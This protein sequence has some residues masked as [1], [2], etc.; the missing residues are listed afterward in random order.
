MRTTNTLNTTRARIVLATS[1]LLV[2]S[3]LIFA[4][5]PIPSVAAARQ[6]L[7]ARLTASPEVVKALS[8]MPDFLL[9]AF[10]A[11]PSAFTSSVTMIASPPDGTPVGGSQVITYTVTV[12]NDDTDDV[13]PPGG[14]LRVSFNTPANTTFLNSF[15]LQQPQTTPAFT[16]TTPPPG[17]TG[18]V[19]CSPPPDGGG[20]REFA[21]FETFKIEISVTVDSGVSVGNTISA[22]A[23]YEYTNAI[24]NSQSNTVNHPVIN[25]SGP[26]ADLRIAKVAYTNGNSGAV[27]AGASD[28]SGEIRYELLWFNNGPNP[29]NGVL[30]T[31]IIPANTIPVGTV[32]AP[33]WTC[34]GDIPTP[35]SQ[36]QCRP[37]YTD[38]GLFQLPIGDNY[39]NTG[40]RIEYVVR[41][42][43]SVPEGTFYANSANITSTPQSGG[44]P[45]NAD[46]NG[47]NNTSL[48]TS[49]VVATKADLVVTKSDSP[50]PVIAG[51]EITYPI[52]ITN[53][54]PSDA[55]NVVLND[56]ISSPLTFVSMN[57]SGA[58]GFTCSTP[59]V[60]GTGTVSCSAAV[61]LAGATANF[62][63]RVRVSPDF[64]GASVSNSA[65]AYASTSDTNLANNCD[66]ESTDVN[67]SADV[68]VVSKL[69]SPD[70]VVAGENLTYSIT[71]RNNGPSTAE[72]VAVT[73]PIPAGTSFVSASATG[74]F[75]GG[76]SLSGG[77]VV[78]TPVG[79]SL[80]PGAV[81]VI[82]LVVKVNPGASGTISNTATI[83]TTTTES[84]TGNN[85]ASSTTTVLVRTDMSIKK[86]GPV[87]VIAGN[88][89]TY[90]IVVRNNGPSD[91][92]SGSVTVNDDLDSR[93]THISNTVTGPVGFTCSAGGVDPVSC[94]SNTVFTAG[95]VATITITF[96]VNNDVPANSVIFNTATVSTTPSSQDPVP[97]NNSSTTSTAG[98]TSADLQLTK[99]ST[100]GSVIAGS[101]AAG[102]EI[103]YTINVL[104]SGPSVANGVVVSD[105]VP[106]NTT[107][108]AQ[109]SFTNTGS[110]SIAMTCSA[111]SAGAQFTCTITGGGAMPVGAAGTIT[112]RVRV[113]ANALNGTIVTN[114]ATIASTGGSATPDPNPANN[115]QDP[116]STL[117]NT[118]AD[119]SVVKDDTGGGLGP[120]PVIAGT[121]VTYRIRVNNA[122]P[123]DAQNV[124][125]TDQLDADTTFVSINTSGAPGFTCVTPAVGS[126]GTV[127]CTRGVVPPGA[128]DYDI[129]LTV[130][131]R[132]GATG[133]VTNLSTVSSS[134]S[135]PSTGNNT[136]GE[137]TTV[138]T[139]AD[140][141]IVSKTDAPDPVS[142]GNELRYIITF[143][144]NGP[145]DA[146]GVSI[147]DTVPTN[148]TFVSV[149]PPL[150]WSCSAP[151]TGGTGTVSCT[152]PGG[153]LPAGAAGEILMVVRVN[154]TV[155][156]TTLSNTAT[157]LTSTSQG[158]ATA[159]DS[160]TQTTTVNINPDLS[161]VKTG[162]ATVTAGNTFTYTLVV[163]NNGPSDAPAN[164]V[165]VADTLSSNLTFSATNVQPGSVG[166]FT[167]SNVG[168]AVTCSNGSVFQ[169]GG[170]ATITITF[171]VNTGVP[172]NTIIFNTATVASVDVNVVDPNTSNNSSTT[173]TAGQTSADLQ[174]T[175]TASPGAVTA[176]SLLAGDEIAYTIN[177]L[178]SGPSVANGVVLSDVV[179]AN[180]I[181][182]SQP[183]FTSTGSPA[184]TMS[185][186]AAAPGAQFTCAV[187]GTSPAGSMPVG[188]A[189]N[190]T[191]RVRVPANVA[192]NTIITNQAE[193]ASTGGSAT[194]DPNPSN[195]KQ[196]PTSTLVNTN[197]NLSISKTDAP[198][199]V[200]AG[201]NVTYT[202]SV[203]N[204]GPSDAQNVVVTDTLPAQVSFLTAT[205]DDPGFVCN[206]SGNVVTCAKA[207]LAAG[208][209]A[210]ITIVA[211]VNPDAAAGSMTNNATIS[212]TTSDPASGNNSTSASTTINTVA[213]VEIVSK[214]DT[215]DPVS[216]GSDLLYTITFRNNG[217][218]DAAGVNITDAVPANTTF[219]SV[220]PPL[221]WSCTAPATGG[222]GT[223]TCSPPNGI[224]PVGASG[225]ILMAVRVNA[226]VSSTTLT[227]TATIATSTSQGGATANDS[228]TQT[229]TVN[230]NPDLSIVKT[231]PATVTAGNVYTYTLV[232]RNNGPSDAPAS[233]VQVADTLD[234]NLTFN[235]T[236][237]QP[238]SVGGFTCSNVGNAV[239]CSNGSVFQA[240][241]VA[242]ITITFTVNNNVPQNTVILNTATVSSVS[243]GVVDPNTS[244]NSSTTSTAGQTS[245]DLQL[246]KTASPASV[247]AGS[248]SSEI[249][250]AINILNSGP[251]VANNVVVSDVVPSNTIVTSQ[252]AFAS[253]GTPAIGLSCTPASAGAQFT[254]VVTGTSPAGSMPVGAAGTITYRVRVPANVAINTI[255]TNQAEI[256][257]TGGS[258]TPDPNPSNNRQAPT[259]TLVNTSADLSITKTDSPDP[260]FA[261]NNVTYTLTVTNS[262]PSDAQN[263]VVT[264]SLP[265]QLS[266]VSATSSD[267][268]FVC[269]NV[270]NTVTCSKAI[271]AASASTTITIIARVN[272]GTADGTVLTNNATVSST[273]SD[274]SSANNSASTTTTVTTDADLTIVKSDSPDPVV[275]GNNLTYTI[276][277]TNNGPSDAR[278]VVLTDPLPAGTQ[279]LSLAGTGVFSAAGACT[280]NG[281]TPG[282]ITCNAT[283]GGILPAGATANV[284]VLVKVLSSV[285]A[286][287]T[288]TNTATV[289]WT[290]A[291]PD[292]D[293][294]SSTA[295][296]LV[297]HESDMTIKK[298]APD[299]VTAG[300]RM[301]YKITVRNTGPSDVDGD[302]TT[303]SI[304]VTDVLPSGTMPATPALAPGNTLLISGPGGFAC[305][306]DMPSNTV[307][308]VNAAGDPGDFPVGSVLT[309][310]IKV[311]VKSSVPAGSNLF[312]CVS[313]ALRGAPDPTPELD[314]APGNNEACD[315]TV[316]SEVL[317]SADLG[318]S[319]T[320]TAV[321]SVPG[322][323]DL[324]VVALP[325]P[326]PNVP[327]GAVKAGGYIQ[328]DVPFG[329]AGPSDAVNVRLTDVVPGN[330]ALVFPNTSP[331]T[332]VTNSTPPSTPVNLECTVTGA[333]GSQQIACSPKGNGP[334]YADGVLP[335]GYTGTLT[336]WVQVNESVSG[337]TIVSNPANITS[338]PNGSQPGTPDA[339]P[340]NNTSLP[341][342]TVVIAASQLS[343]TKIV[344]SGVTAA[345][346]PNQTGPIGPA[347][348]SGGSG[349]TGTAVLPGTH[350]TYRITIT[351]NGPSDV[352]NL[353]VTDTLPAGL[354][355]PPGRVLGVKY[356]SVAQTSGFGTTFTCA[357]PT[358]INPSNNPQGNGGLLQCTAPL[359]SANAPNNTATID[360][361]VFI[362]PATRANLV[363]N[364]RVDATINNFNQ[365]TAATTT[366]TTPVAPTSDLALTKTHAPDPVIAG[367]E[368]EY[369]VTLTNNGPSAAQTVSLVDTF[370]AFQKVLSVQVMQTPDGNGAPNFTCTASPSIG[371]P[372]NTT[373]L[374]CTAAE[375]PPNRR[376]DNTVNPSGTVTFKIRVLQDPLT[377][378]PAPTA[379]QNCVSATSGSTD[380]VSG[381]STSV[382]DTVNILFRSDLSITKSDSPDPVIAGNNLTYT[383]NATNNGPSAAL[384]M[385]IT[386]PLPTGTVF[387]SASAPGSSSLLTPAVGANGTVTATW[388][389][390]TAPGV[391][392]TLT[393]VVRVCP[394]FQQI[395]NL[396][397]AQMCVPNLTD[398]ATVSSDTP[399]LNSA[400]NS[401]TAETTVQAQSDLSI[402]KTGPAQ[403]AHSTSNNA[404]IVTYTIT[405]SNAGPSNA[406]GVAIVD[407]L[408]KGFTVAETAST[409]PGT[410]FSTT[411]TNGVATVTATIGVLGAANQCG[412]TP[413]PTS[414]T[415][416]IRAQVPIKHPTIT[417]TNTATISTTNCLADPNLANNTATF[418]TFITPPA[419]DPGNAFPALAEVGD[420]K[421]G[422]ILFYPIYT[423]DA[424]N[425][426]TQ[427]A[428]INIT[429]TSP[430]ERICVHL[431]AVDGASC[432]VL[433]AFICLTPNQTA[434][435]LASD[436]D[437]GNTGYL[438]ALSVDCD[439]GLPKA[440]NYLIGDQY[441]KFTSGHQANLAAIAVAAVT[442]F[443]GGTNPNATTTTL[444]FDGLN[445]N[446]LA[447]VVAA[448][449]IQST[450][451]NNSTMLV[452]NRV[453]GN[454]TLGGAL[455]GG[456]A[457][458][459]YDDAEASFSFTSNQSSCQFRTIMSNNFPRTFTPFTRV[460]PA[461]RTGWMKFWGVDDSR[462]SDKA[463]FGSM[464]NFNPSANANANAYNQ[465]HN[466]HH[467]TLT[468]K[469]EI[470]VPIFIPSC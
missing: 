382:C 166:G 265:S 450:A 442:V 111:A 421:A 216:A 353:R 321:A 334:T 339:N 80:P 228:K 96:S 77:S 296:T 292:A 44:R 84:N 398:T 405:F 419:S 209:S 310:I 359:M 368:F 232:V 373:S 467:L 8:Y 147:S 404:S 281:A 275:A 341:T 195:N 254:C 185:C 65:C 223:V 135:D 19:L 94:T 313:V 211:R 9:R 177:I 213:D 342:S 22:F 263:V 348:V 261:G 325:T 297:I 129:L 431:F 143:R 99:T 438:M 60:G 68:E 358:G 271:L 276:T 146:A 253:T 112:Y 375:L 120:D 156:S 102:D 293:T 347:S 246:V 317:T 218:S 395:R 447:R 214:T 429:N 132:T 249:T 343:I 397:D 234:A 97:D 32:G 23:L 151:A 168:N 264:D 140:V 10:G 454:F 412:A 15:I 413:R 367:T 98:G 446:R 259:S 88:T 312:N 2:I 50:D 17:T 196:A 256:A 255:V 158:G 226:T 435:F 284:T 374:T 208:A 202:L 53:N 36:L 269:V 319:K 243:G 100:P 172:Q 133:S 189:G 314:P 346:N 385:V 239:T 449:N 289:N 452:V 192:I 127:S 72:N 424:A 309:I 392:R 287:T 363:N 11:S 294:A 432:A 326:G 283:P 56:T 460:I 355:T 103:V 76:C 233:S 34:N 75:A 364:A 181:V 299:F 201:T 126:S 92:P 131:V 468:D 252:P 330:T 212:S 20:V 376:Q 38:P 66:S 59:S 464:I 453:G 42:A 401:A 191:Y 349:T 93:L 125:V 95:A 357:P 242:T 229:T 193:I 380:P 171:T 285:T 308:C 182:T 427:N 190:I 220:T 298:E 199:P 360:V 169:A 291:D 237:V 443:P 384:N 117:I 324:P 13:A 329:N 71:V 170:V 48:P 386:D 383:I 40:F 268:G 79:G 194:P 332:I 354:E 423:S 188:A 173:S 49:T 379:Y 422:S 444:K 74:L 345:S 14:T 187:T 381:N 402:G 455:V 144:N 340:G 248:V 257:S 6:S 222:T 400:N 290:D 328:Y 461:G 288:L 138:N 258:A 393:I 145:S 302:A 350:L 250:Y 116:T 331:F 338:A 417:V 286:N 70:P 320:A 351:N 33:G 307:T 7:S 12:T 137:T 266:L 161:I 30:I 83:A 466:L 388:A 426:N 106:A 244:N 344:Q 26:P 27:C 55:R 124:S 279:Y 85:S 272:P 378:Q 241:G 458:L 260:V 113:P 303:G 178:N 128:T 457:G 219:V 411:T 118:S 439:T 459:L 225:Q 337:G 369:T 270:N 152:P 104:N 35:G 149:N 335:A 142:A 175:K 267:A 174:L 301:D 352:S 114:G 25:P 387:I 1:A 278:S 41:V 37:I 198:D 420:Q 179:P 43:S 141:E 469:A 91:A 470:V 62:S 336:F 377:P 82:T 31:D 333:P 437:P 61:L 109:P 54:G 163:R 206:H 370:P 4:Y 69:D 318:V 409:V 16:C 63:L 108:T 251:S 394:D 105:F 365:P 236:N 46:P 280:H 203:A 150:A 136:E 165:E 162:P 67:V 123:S 391:T 81:S 396:T 119:L 262:G 157:I 235:T 240:G 434:S 64:T 408:P 416:T 399:D 430:T 418:D 139:Q 245:A 159:N 52:S 167:C 415:I 115:K 29:A 445:Y 184:I 21:S 47:G 282:A 305:S 134:T 372:G 154:T 311:Q 51:N 39:L 130:K 316:A 210:T 183:S 433:D 425:S 448:D 73:D 327:P 58:S 277:V 356:V 155:S 200:T 315:A 389:G 273:T 440:C 441:V 462:G 89:Y 101:A 406:N 122:G 160:K 224:L 215:P 295:T 186:A 371:S 5:A 407:V 45:A 87:T 110:P 231:G 3:G 90:T 121:N 180:T 217:P 403:A 306:Y 366:L 465:G 57:A 238:G 247:T 322:R 436:F 78:C 414:G 205:S 456:I 204:A 148:T 24:G 28:P 221:L 164:S 323:P 390:L 410:S 86:T 428:R 176:G 230:I 361:T 362:D 451:D 207:T 274:P 153:A 227:N 197:A 463:L 18:A 107:V 300:T 304:T